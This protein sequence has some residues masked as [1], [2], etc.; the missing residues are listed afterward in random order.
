ME[1]NEEI[2]MEYATIIVMLA[3]AEYIYFTVR[4]GA[5]RGKHKVDA[6]ACAGNEIFE[7]SFRVQQNT[8]EQ[9][10]IFIPATFAFAYYVDPAWVILP[11]AVFIIGRFLYSSEYMNDPKSRAP[12]MVATLRS[13]NSLPGPLP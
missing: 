3:L 8:L 12:G 13:H 5:G 4:V 2:N 6:P 1:I 11:G 10:I 7:R 9:L